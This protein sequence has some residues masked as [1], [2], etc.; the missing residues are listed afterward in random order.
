ML[1]RA[2]KCIIL[3]PAGPQRQRVM[4]TLYRDKRISNIDHHCYS[5]LE[6][7][8][9]ERFVTP[10]N[11]AIFENLLAVHQRATGSDGT[12][13]FGRAIIE[14]NI[15]AAARV[16]ST[17][18][19]TSLSKLLGIDID[20]TEKIAVRM[21]SENRLA[22]SIDQVENF[23]IFHQNSA[24]VLPTDLNNQTNENIQ[25]VNTII[26]YDEKIKS[27][28]VNINSVVEKVAKTFPQIPVLTQQKLELKQKLYEEEQE[29]IKQE[30]LLKKQQQQG[31]VPL[32]TTTSITN[33]DNTG[34]HLSSQRR[35]IP[36]I[37]LPGMVE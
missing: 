28:C 19:F 12:T 1:E 7:M 13:V 8:Y 14:H 15:F 11:A 5:M 9:M 37:N 33:D 31:L 35:T 25:S 34:S 24:N 26:G 30:K 2:T 21:I 20:R 18:T 29:K 4:G 27:I 36:N 10:A 23:L 3:A 17:I 16:Y 32:T 6:R 22:A